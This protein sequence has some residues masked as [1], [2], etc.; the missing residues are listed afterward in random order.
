MRNEAKMEGG[1]KIG[2]AEVDCTPRLGLPIMGHFRDEYGA[3]GIH[4]P[5][6]A[7]AIVVSDA[8]GST[9]AMVTADICM[10]GRDQVAI[11]REHVSKSCA[12]PGENILVAATH[13]HGSMAP[14][15]LYITPTAPQADIEKF[16]RCAGDAVVK[17]MRTARPGVLQAGRSTEERLSFNR[18]LRCRDGSMHMNWEQID[19]TSVVCTLGPIDP[20][21]RTLSVNFDGR[22]AA[23]VVNFALHPAILDYE[24]SLYTGDYVGYLSEAL[25]AINGSGFISAFFNCCCGN[26]NHIDYADK[27]S[28][29]RGYVMAQRVGYMLAARAQQ[30][31]ADSVPLSSGIVRVSREKVNLARFKISKELYE[32]SR[33]FLTSGPDKNFQPIDGLDLHYGAPLWVRMYEEQDKPDAVEVMAIRIGDAAVVGLPGEVFVEL[34]LAIKKQSPAKHTFVIELANGADGYFPTKQAF[35]EGGYEIMPGATKYEPGSGERLVDSAV[36]QLK[37]LF[38]RQD[39]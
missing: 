32:K 1:F 35:S 12:I 24:N 16:A 31:S 22:P 36:Q 21:V 29:R 15:S 7:R 38:E 28:P 23:S 14:Q 20:E 25:K 17:A 39:I 34:A 8:S 33:Q 26:I 11:V 27:D 37:T 13:T 2:V 30:A 4:D 18:R 3:T 19:P 6:M 5:L 10:L 9:A